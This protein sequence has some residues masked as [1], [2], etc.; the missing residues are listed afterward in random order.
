MAG[1]S[2]VVTV[3][4]VR[5]AVNV[6]VPHSPS[7]PGSTTDVPD[8]ATTYT[9]PPGPDPDQP[10]TVAPSTGGSDSTPHCGGAAT[11]CCAQTPKPHRADPPARAAA[12]LPA[13]DAARAPGDP[14]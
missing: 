14:A 2:T 5:P 12:P 6:D 4:L 9:M 8:A 10:R 7:T 1:A 3:P 13:G 11:P